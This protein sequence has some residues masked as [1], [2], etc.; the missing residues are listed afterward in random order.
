MFVANATNQPHDFVYRLPEHAAAI[1][2]PIRAGGQVQLPGDLRLK[3]VEAIIEQHRLYGMIEAGEIARLGSR[4]YAGLCY[5][6]DRQ[7]TPERILTLY[8]HNTSV[9]VERGKKLRTDSAIAIHENMQQ[10]ALEQHLPDPLRA[11]ETTVEEIHR[12]ARD[13]S[14]EINEGV[15]VAN[16]LP[17][18]VTVAGKPRRERASRR[19]TIQ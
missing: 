13:P 5:S 10:Q 16:D 6:L 14:P 11:L 8:N 9:L 19:A 2:V 1:R 3:D 12:D 4:P 7:T 18:G 17:R 15:R